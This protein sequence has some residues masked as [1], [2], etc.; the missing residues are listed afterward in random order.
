ML[1]NNTKSHVRCPAGLTDSFP[2]TVG[3]HQGSALSPLLF[4][5]VMNSITRDLQKCVPWTL[6]YADDVML[7]A[8]SRKDLETQVQTWHDR[9]QGFGLRLNIH[10]TEY[11]ETIPSPG[12]IGI[13]GAPLTKVNTFRYLGSR[14]NGDSSVNED[15]RARINA[16]WMRF[17]DVTGVLCDK[18]MPI[19]LKSKIYRTMVKPVALY[20]CIRGMHSHPLPITIN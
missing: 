7:A 20:C 8:D 13:N 12:T 3:V 16:T 1:Y 11:L 15:V 14:L 10:K 19:R 18:K 17:R 5:I 2:V 6:L 9:L 4:V